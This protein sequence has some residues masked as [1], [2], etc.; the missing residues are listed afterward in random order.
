MKYMDRKEY[1]SKI[2]VD[3]YKPIYEFSSDVST[4]EDYSITV[5]VTPTQDL[6]KKG[7]ID[8][9]SE[10]RR[11]TIQEAEEARTKQIQSTQTWDPDEI[12]ELKHRLG[13]NDFDLVKE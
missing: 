2:L 10:I 1:V 9:F 6:F 12:E 7:Q 5:Y 8:T 4:E 11:L 13:V 3:G